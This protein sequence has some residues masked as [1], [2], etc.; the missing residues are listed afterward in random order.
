MGIGWCRREVG[1]DLDGLAA[2]HRVTRMGF[3]AIANMTDSIRKLHCSS[4]GGLAL[5]GGSQPDGG[6]KPNGYFL[7]LRAR[8]APFGTYSSCPANAGIS[9]FLPPLP[10]YPE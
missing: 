8:S 1:V 2:T 3:F 6:D 4:I 10:D 5:A 9:A 7:S